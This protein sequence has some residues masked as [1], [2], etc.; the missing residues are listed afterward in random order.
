M[1]I[2]RAEYIIA[3]LSYHAGIEG[4]NG[5][6]YATNRFVEKLTSFDLQKGTY[7]PDD[8]T[9]KTYWAYHFG[10]F[11]Q[12]Y[13]GSLRQIGLI[14]EPVDENGQFFGI[15]R[16]TSRK[17]NNHVSGEELAT[18]FDVN[19]KPQNKQLF[20]GC[21]KKGFVNISELEILT[22]DFNLKV[23]SQNSKEIELLKQILMDIDEPSAPRDNVV[24]MRKETIIH[25]MRY[26]SANEYNNQYDFTRYAYNFKGKFNNTYDNCLLGWYYYQFNEY[27]QTVCTAM[28]NATLD[29]LE[30][31]EGPGWINL[32]E[33]INYLK[34]EVLAILKKEKIITNENTSIQTILKLLKNPEDD[35][36]EKIIQVKKRERLYYAFLQVWTLYNQN[37]DYLNVLNDYAIERQIGENQEDVLSYFTGFERYFNLN[38]SKFIYDFLSVHVI[39]RHQYVAY[40]KIGGGSQSTQKFIIENNFIRKI[41]NF[42]PGFTS[43]R[44]ITV[45]SFLTTLNLIDDNK[46]LSEFGKSFLNQYSE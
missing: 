8:S 3:L 15:Y 21:I 16:R 43:P 34:D 12:Y 6:L 25:L 13:L 42:E 22:S 9:S 17:D 28:L 27:W 40:R 11:G 19:I 2:R 30:E 14:E 38:V 7:N 18:A 36:Y 37:K 31:L 24:E 29:I 45:M 20:L 35:L 4:V 5:V 1:F 10:I 26:I 23:I 41:G 32:H 46:K 33:L 39:T 44:I